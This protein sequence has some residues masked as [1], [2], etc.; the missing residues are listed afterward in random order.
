MFE[1]LF[2]DC[3]LTAKYLDTLGRLFAE[4]EGELYERNSTLATEFNEK[5]LE[6]AYEDHINSRF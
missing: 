3:A 5:L 2:A 4:R 1:G 6:R